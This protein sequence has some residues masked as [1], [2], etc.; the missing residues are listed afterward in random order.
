[1]GLI[2]TFLLA[3][4]L[5]PLEA[6]SAG[7][8]QSRWV[9]AAIEHHGEVYTLE[10]VGDSDGQ[11]VIVRLP[12]ADVTVRGT[13]I[14][15]I[16]Q[17]GISV[18]DDTLAYFVTLYDPDR[19]GG[20]LLYG[21]Y[22]LQRERLVSQFEDRRLHLP[23]AMLTG[24]SAIGEG[25]MYISSV[26]PDRNGQR[27]FWIQRIRLRDGYLRPT[28]RWGG[29][30]GFAPGGFAY[31]DLAGPEAFNVA[32]RDGQD[33]LS[34]VPIADTTGVRGG[35]YTEGDR[36]YS[37]ERHE[38]SFFVFSRSF[39]SIEHDRFEL[40]GVPTAID[41]LS[42]SGRR[43]VFISILSSAHGPEVVVLRDDGHRLA[44]RHRVEA[45]FVA[46]YTDGEGE[47][48]VLINGGDGQPR[49]RRL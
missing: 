34:A 29:A 11:R 48:V 31:H 24:N 49:E 42:C 28:G 46:P 39:A 4:A 10:H 18:H 2:L 21:T 5:P 19:R 17:F 44:V 47:C 14:E 22:D 32:S 25:E 26:F 16:D 40:R 36:F 33:I 37:V 8:G 41:A 43:L 45:H 9:L 13:E 38:D 23:S 7:G 30:A 20:A 3:I 6:A 12:E 15:A 27:G 35:A 1:M